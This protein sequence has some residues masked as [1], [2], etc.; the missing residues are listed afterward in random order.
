[1]TI[2]QRSKA[3]PDV[4]PEEVFPKQECS[5]RSCMRIIITEDGRTYE[6]HTHRYKRIVRITSLR[7]MANEL[8]DLIMEEPEDERGE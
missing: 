7:E 8:W 2:T 6:M 1:M 3:S 5:V 4:G